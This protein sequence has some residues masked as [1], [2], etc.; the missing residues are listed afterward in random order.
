[1][2]R[3]D[4]AQELTQRPAEPGTAVQQIEQ[5]RNGAIHALREHIQEWELLNQARSAA[6]SLQEVVASLPP[7]WQYPEITAARVEPGV[8]DFT[9]THWTQ[10]RDVFTH[11]PDGQGRALRVNSAP[12]RDS[13]GRVAGTVGIFQDV[14]GRRQ[15]ER[16]LEQ[17]NRDL[18]LLYRSSQLLTSTLELQRVLERSVE[19]TA[20]ITGAQ[21]SSV[22]LWD[23]EHPDELVCRA[24]FQ[25]G[26]GCAPCGVR[27]RCGQG[28]VGWVAQNG[29][30]TMIRHA[31]DDSRFDLS[32][33]G[34][35]GSHAV[36]LLAVPLRTQDAVIGVLE[37]VIEQ[38][39]EFDA[40]DLALV[41]TLGST[42]AIAIQN[43]QLVETQRQCALTLQA[44]NEELGA[45]A[46]TVAHDLKNPLNLVIGYAETMADELANLPQEDLIHQLRHIGQIGF[47]MNEIINELL[48][49]AGAREAEADITTLDMA[50]IVTEALQRLVPLVEEYRA[51]LVLPDT[52]GWP[53]ALGHAAWIEEV[54]VNYIT[55]ALKYGG[56]P[57]RV[58]LGAEAA[59]GDMVRFWVRDNG[60]G[61]LPEEQARLF[62]PFTRLH[63][64]G[65]TGNG[66]GLSIVRQIVER[67][68]GRV[69]LK[70]QKGQGSVFS[71]VL[72]AASPV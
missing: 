9:R 8:P 2:F 19:I 20:D 17:R 43:A 13:Q 7:A 32:V 54:W 4:Q 55:N 12:I 50:G 71:F 1:M 15:V 40:H 65:D 52:S 33:D 51:E 31:P 22:W 16:E 26:V 41:E 23:R 69:E 53:V 21:C 3:N 60:C 38:S 63:R 42:A 61:L 64:E 57:P 46:R 36:S 27:A 48:L 49:L 34:Q 28:M 35:V 62:K 58:E 66:L 59:P 11:E 72:P 24:A 14:A 45:F 30:G 70:S 68:G 56:R 25:R 10:N 44:R 39:G 18:T 29:K 37:A 6:E 67:L 5:A 47:K